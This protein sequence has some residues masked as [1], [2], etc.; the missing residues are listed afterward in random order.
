MKGKI[1]PN[2]VMEQ[3]VGA[4]FTKNDAAKFS[5]AGKGGTV[6][7]NGV[8]DQAVGPT[9]NVNSTHAPA[10]HPKTTPKPTKI[11]TT[12]KGE[13]PFTSGHAKDASTVGTSG[14]K[15]ASC[16]KATYGK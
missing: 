7:S 1:K 14:G 9:Y 2:G 8:I 16:L 15:E 5:G 13:D 11:L 6:K 12:G 10:V 4:T 3:A